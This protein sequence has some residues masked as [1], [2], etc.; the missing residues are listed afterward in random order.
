MFSMLWRNLRKAG[1]SKWALLGVL[2]AVGCARP[3]PSPQ[4]SSTV[5]NAVPGK[6][7]PSAEVSKASSQPSAKVVIEAYYPF[8]EKHQFIADYLKTLPQKYGPDVSVEL[9]DMETEE[10]QARWEKTGLSCGGVFVNGKTSATLTE[11]GK[12][13]KVKFLSRMDVQWQ[14]SDLEKAIEQELQRAK[15]GKP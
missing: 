11:N 1:R 15:E 10:G 14:R 12:S 6:G 9:I 4:P 2:A 5:A 7:A 8:N 3:G 13:R